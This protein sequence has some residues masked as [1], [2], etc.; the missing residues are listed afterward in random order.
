MERFF[1]RTKSKT[2]VIHQGKQVV[3]TRFARRLLLRLHRHGF[4]ILI[5]LDL[6]HESLNSRPFSHNNTTLFSNLRLY[7]PDFILIFCAF[8]HITQCKPLNMTFPSK[9][10]LEILQYRYIRS[11]SW[12]Y[13]WTWSVCAF[14]FQLSKFINRV[15]RFWPAG[16]TFNNPDLTHAHTFSRRHWKVIKDKGLNEW[17]KS[18]T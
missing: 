18:W 5:Y 6:Q 11:I 16:L 2:S 17:G 10:A 13:S 8:E 4:M 12:K 3:L 9:R 1:N 7:S 14:F 15:T